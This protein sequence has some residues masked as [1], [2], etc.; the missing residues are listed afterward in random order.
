MSNIISR[1]IAGIGLIILGSIFLVLS[2]FHWKLLIYA[3]SFLVL[4]IWIFLNDKEDDIEKIK[5]NG[6]KRK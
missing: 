4:G 6:R 1:T 2:F 5:Y 3:I